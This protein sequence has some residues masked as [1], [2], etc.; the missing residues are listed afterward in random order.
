MSEAQVTRE[1]LAQEMGRVVSDSEQLLKSVGT[2]GNEKAQE[3]RR[4]IEE[5]LRVAKAR[6]VELQDAAR[7]TGQ[8]A[9]RATD[10]YVH[11]NPWTSLAAAAGVAALI[12]LA[13]GLMLNRDR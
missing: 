1:K 6:L 13:V 4:G 9:A 5:N 3:L 10:Q 2:A 8:E 11:T 12:G 7:R